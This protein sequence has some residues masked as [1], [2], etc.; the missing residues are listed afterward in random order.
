MSR[1]ARSSRLAERSW[2]ARSAGEN[3]TP[4]VTR[5][6]HRS[7]DGLGTMRARQ[8][9]RS[10]QA[11]SESADARSIA[12][13]GARPSLRP[14]RGSHCPF[15]PTAALEKI[16]ICRQY[17]RGQRSPPFGGS[18]GLV[19]LRLIARSAAT[20]EAWPSPASTAAARS[21]STAGGWLGGPR[22]RFPRSGL[23][24]DRLAGA[25]VTVPP[26]ASAVTDGGELLG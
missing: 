1:A 22:R 19:C 26:S 11:S 13:T 10:F 17:Q 23:D 14:A 18:D 16:L 25:A 21:P 12:T 7:C 3:S 15:C 5:T 24:A 8:T 9:P 6:V 4:N 20:T 2:S